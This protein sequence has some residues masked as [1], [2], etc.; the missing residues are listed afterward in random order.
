MGPCCSGARRTLLLGDLNRRRSC[1]W[2]WSWPCPR[3][4]A[5]LHAAGEHLGWPWTPMP[6]MRELGREVSGLRR[7]PR[8]GAWGSAPRSPTPPCPPPPIPAASGLCAPLA[9]ALAGRGKAVKGDGGEGGRPAPGPPR[10]R[11]LCA[12]GTGFPASH[13]RF[14]FP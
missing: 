6:G 8:T 14:L 10:P 1:P 12:F 4:K 9:G 5:A 13:S 11:R 3:R 2:S 7:A